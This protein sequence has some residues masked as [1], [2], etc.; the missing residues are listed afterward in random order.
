MTIAANR[1]ILQHLVI[2]TSIDSD[3]PFDNND[4]R[5]EFIAEVAMAS[6]QKLMQQASIYDRWETTNKI[7][8]MS[9]KTMTPRGTILSPIIK[10]SP[11]SEGNRGYE[12]EMRQSLE[13]PQK[14]IKDFGKQ[15][16]GRNF[17]NLKLKS[18]T[19]THK[20]SIL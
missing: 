12:F 3:S 9:P 13:L 2:D 5:G 6:S 19:P 18:L 15:R 17:P 1:L 20:T 16:C 10:Q 4:I 11:K 7:V 14:L 8:F